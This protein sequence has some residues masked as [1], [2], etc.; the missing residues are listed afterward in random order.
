[1][2]TSP[3]I[4]HTITSFTSN[5][6]DANTSSTAF[7]SQ[8]L[9]NIT[10]IA[11]DTQSGP[12]GHVTS[13][14][15][16]ILFAYAIASAG[17]ANLRVH[18]VSTMAHPVRRDLTRI[19]EYMGKVAQARATLTAATPAPS[20]AAAATSTTA[21]TNASRVKAAASEESDVSADEAAPIQVHKH[22]KSQAG[23]VGASN[24]KARNADDVMGKAILGNKEHLHWRE[25]LKS[26]SKSRRASPSPAKQRGS[27]KARR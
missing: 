27:K 9:S 2:S 14:E 17:Y 13:A 3:T 24:V 21:T 11:Q 20:A 19:Q 15:T 7:T 5:L 12:L 4:S 22:T 25:Q 6:K 16:A 18:G 1:M 10:A 23:I 26:M 8:H